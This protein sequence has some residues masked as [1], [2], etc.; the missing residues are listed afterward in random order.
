MIWIGGQVNL[1][2]DGAVLNP[3]NLAAQ[4]AAVVENIGRVLGELEAGLDDLVYLNAF[5]VND[6]SLDERVFLDLIAA[7]L[8]VGTRTAI[9]P[10]PVGWLAYEGMLVEIEGYAMRGADGRTAC[11]VTMHPRPR[12]GTRA[13]IAF[14]TALRC[15]KM[16]FVSAQSAIDCKRARF[17]GIGSTVEQS[18]NTG[19][20]ICERA[21]NHFGADFDDVVKTNRWYC[22]R[23]GDRRLRTC[24]ARVCR[25]VSMRTGSRRDRGADPSTRRPRTN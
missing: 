15:G 19:G 17:R 2:A 25:H 4:T 12:P 16:I 10:I 8:P 23:R 13:P 24:G 20:L 18:R 7:A 5:Y 3:G 11:R 6:G 14:C 1:T 22:G 9:T 21:L